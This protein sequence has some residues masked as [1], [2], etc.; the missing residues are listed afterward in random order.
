[1]RRLLWG[2]LALAALAIGL[3]GY[4][5]AMARLA[6]GTPPEMLAAKAQADAIEV[7]KSARA[8]RLMREGREVARYRVALGAAPVGQKLREGDERTPVGRYVIDWRNPHSVAHL[9]LHISY[10]NA[11]DVARAK[12]A[13]VAPGGNIMIHG[14]PNGWGVV[15]R[16]HRLLDWTNGCIGVSD[17]EMDEIWARVP[18]GTPI[19]IFE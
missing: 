8:L 6:P 10:P 18:N 11:E 1:M 9:S 2:A 14:L 3:I 16:W 15:G 13:G 19:T 17:A 4:T 5:K 7:V 12:A